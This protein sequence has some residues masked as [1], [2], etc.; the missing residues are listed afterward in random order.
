MGSR[1]DKGSNNWDK[2]QRSNERKKV[3]NIKEK[4]KLP[5]SGGLSKDEM[6]TLISYLNAMVVNVLME[7]DYS[8]KPRNYIT[9]LKWS[10]RSRSK[11]SGE[12]SRQKESYGS[13]RK[14]Q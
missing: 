7:K 9:E 3:V 5:F 14:L 12:E 8:R 4:K 13:K 2:W 6:E 10:T 11:F 1:G